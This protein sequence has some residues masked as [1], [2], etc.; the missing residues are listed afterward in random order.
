MSASA[1]PTGTVAVE[2]QPDGSIK[3]YFDITEG[4]DENATSGGLHVHTRTSCAAA[5]DV[6]GYCWRDTS[7]KRFKLC[8]L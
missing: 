1:A 8:E 6:G 2:D 3:V 7:K 4:F 5:L